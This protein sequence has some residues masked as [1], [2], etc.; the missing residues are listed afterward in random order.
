M[1]FLTC[2]R[3]PHNAALTERVVDIMYKAR[4]LRKQLVFKWVPLENNVC[5]DQICCEKY[6][7]EMWCTGK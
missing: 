6:K 7:A 1:R 3:R 5:T 4:Q 2:E